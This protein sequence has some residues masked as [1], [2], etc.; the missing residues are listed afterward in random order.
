MTKYV[1]EYAAMMR[2]AILGLNSGVRRSSSTAECL[3]PCV[4]VRILFSIIH[5]L[6]ERLGLL[7]VRE[8]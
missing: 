6:L 2:L 3:G 1:A 8:R 4:L 5:L 7:I